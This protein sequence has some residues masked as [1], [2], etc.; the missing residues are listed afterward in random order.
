MTSGYL[1]DDTDSPELMDAQPFSR[2]DRFSRFE[3][4]YETM[5]NLLIEGACSGEIDCRGTIVVAEGA[6]VNA[7][8]TARDAR[9]AGMLDGELDCSGRF[10][11]LPSG[12]ASGSVRARQIVVHEGAQYDGELQMTG[13]SPVEEPVAEPSAWESTFGPEPESEF[14]P[15][16]GQAAEEP[17]AAAD[18]ALPAVEEENLPDFLKPRRPE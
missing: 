4:R 15:E 9:V 13:A 2:V 18:E 16:P 1:R 10:E 7:R 17:A 12:R 8:V 3:G 5:Q 6:S 14:G 11:L